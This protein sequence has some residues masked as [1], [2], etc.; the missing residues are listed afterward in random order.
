MWF[1]RSLGGQ[2]LSCVVITPWAAAAVCVG[3]DEMETAQLFFDPDWTCIQVANTY[4]Q[5][6][7]VNPRLSGL[8]WKRAMN[9]ITCSSRFARISLSSV[10][11]SQ[12]KLYIN[13]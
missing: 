7:N 4:F 5:M 11:A 10:R 3:K 8:T 9:P 1:Y 13:P 2:E 6:S 12:K